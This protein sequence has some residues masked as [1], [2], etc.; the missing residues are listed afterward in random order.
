MPAEWERHVGTWIAWPHLKEH[1][2]GYF[3]SIPSVFGQM[4]EA[5]SHSEKIFVCVND[6]K[7]ENEA[8]ELLQKEQP[9]VI[10]DNV[11]FYHIPTN[12]SWMRDHGPIFVQGPDGLNITDWIFNGW[13]NR[14]P[15]WK[16]DLDDEVPQRVAEQFKLPLVQPGLV[17]EGGSIDVNGKGTLLTTESCLLSPTRNPHLSRREI[18]EAL[19]SYLG[20]THVIWLKEELK[21]DDTSGHIDDLARFV[22]PDIVVACV[23]R[24]KEDENY[25]VLKNNFE[26]LKNSTDQ[27]GKPLNIITLPMPAPVMHEGQRCPASY[28]NF[29]IGNQVVLLPT[30]RC[31]QDDEATEILEKYFPNRKI[32]GIDCFD[33]VWGLG[34]IHCS[35]QQ[36]PKPA[37][38]R[39]DR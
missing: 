25:E 7:M 34:A 27:D 21:G 17:L 36:Q 11:F 5:L 6:E 33:L 26:L 30:Y 24:N 2:P 15:Q 29:Y 10:W 9:G 18:E 32:V 14:W 1:W 22:S 8:R 37:L 4:A 38:D 28:A 12:S 35:T 31:K 16:Y 3:G 13:G 19:E 23:E 39:T 20:A